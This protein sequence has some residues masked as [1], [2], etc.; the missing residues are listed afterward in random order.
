MPKVKN[1]KRKASSA[2]GK[3]DKAQTALIMSNNKRI[4]AL[5]E[6]VEKKY[7]YSWGTQLGVAS[8]DPTSSATRTAGITPARS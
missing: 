6:S 5:E 7:N 1:A 3:V 8:F 4:S 2:R